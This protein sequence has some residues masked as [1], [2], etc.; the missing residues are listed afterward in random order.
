M[1]GMSD[2]EEAVAAA[3]RAFQDRR[4]SGKS[5]L[6]RK[7]ILLKLATL[8]ER[9]REELALLECLDVGKPI[10][11]AWRFD[12]PTAAACLRFNAEAADKH[13]GKVYAADRT[14][15]SYELRRPVG[16]VAGI[17]GWNFPLYLAA[18]KIGPVLA[19]GNCLILKPSELTAFS[20]A[21]LAELAVE[22][23]L[24]PGVFNVVYGEASVGA[25]LARHQDVDLLTFTGSTQTGRQLMMAAGQSNM[26]RLL[27]ECGGKAPNIVFEAGPDLDAV[28]EASV[29]SAFWN[30]GQVC[31]AS[32]RLL[33]QESIKEE[34]LGKVI[35]KTAALSAGDPLKPETRF[36]ALV[37][38]AQQRKVLAYIESGQKE[39]ARL[40]HQSN[41][42]VPFEN[43]FFVPPTIFDDVAPTHRI[44]Q[45][46]IFGPV[47]S[48][49]TFREEQD[50]IRIANSTIYGLS[51]TL[52]T[53]DLG[54][55]HRV[56]Q[57][58]DAGWIT[59][60]ATGQIT[61]GPGESV[62]SVGGLKQSGIGM[63]G[64]IEGLEQYMTRSAVQLFV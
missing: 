18:Q 63:E 57:S 38:R 19:A 40:V 4:W 5:V 53:R 47:L 16:V 55:A 42:R 2:V 32:S 33:I 6:A 7:D 50:A 54:R 56:S 35:R 22:A 9:H 10:G 44:A 24:P 25:A 60:N 59:V 26:K 17:I 36:G 45:E 62:I 39:G 34:L 21:R 30:Q 52:W 51:A 49:L 28:A 37:S 31:V 1:A 64:G 13:W 23:G 12:V 11:D 43:G 14:S 58:I 61:G 3:R 41:A 8:I 46:E 29:N 20:A 27:L 48:V 15:L